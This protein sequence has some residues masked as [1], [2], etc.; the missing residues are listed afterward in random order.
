VIVTFTLTGLRDL[1]SIAAT[2]A[3]LKRVFSKTMPGSALGFTYAWLSSVLVTLM[4]SVIW[5]QLI[6]SNEKGQVQAYPHRL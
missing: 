2:L 4:L 5:N 3:W 6:F 1:S